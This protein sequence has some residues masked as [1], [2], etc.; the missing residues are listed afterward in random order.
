MKQLF[1]GIFLSTFLLLL[2]ACGGG[3][4]DK[5]AQL[6]PPPVKPPVTETPKNNLP[7]L[8]FNS[9]LELDEL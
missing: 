3:G 8:S 7:V 4:D 2:S 1:K 6:V 5:A 9:L